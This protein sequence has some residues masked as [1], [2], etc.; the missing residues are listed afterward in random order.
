MRKS[1]RDDEFWQP[2]V[3][4]SAAVLLKNRSPCMNAMQLIN[5]IVLYHSGITVSN[6]FK[7]VSIR[8]FPGILFVQTYYN[9]LMTTIMFLVVLRY[10][11][12]GMS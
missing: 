1:K 4:M 3:C 10:E 8:C 2:F 11:E 12:F 5:T 7:S 9:V 6:F